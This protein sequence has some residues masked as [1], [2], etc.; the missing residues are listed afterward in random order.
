[1]NTHI[2]IHKDMLI[3]DILEA[4]P[5][6]RHVI[7]RHFG[8]G[9]LEPPGIMWEKLSDAALA[10]GRDVTSIMIEIAELPE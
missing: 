9:M 5:A 7:V 10:H 8:E 4:F 3:G 2:N 6:A 1:M